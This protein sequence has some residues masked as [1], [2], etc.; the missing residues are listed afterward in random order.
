[1]GMTDKQFDTFLRFILTDLKE[2]QEET[3]Q[4]KKQ[5]KVQEIIDTLQK[6]LE[7]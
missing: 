3:D 7:D 4:D 6:A 2:V 5:R 1:M